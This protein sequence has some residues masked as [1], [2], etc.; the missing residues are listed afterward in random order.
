MKGDCMCR[1]GLGWMCEVTRMD[2][3]RNEY[4]KGR[5]KVVPEK[6]RSNR[7]AWHGHVM[8]RDEIHIKKE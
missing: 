4:I 3:I 8:R 7:L 1:K 6:M 5:L 2:R